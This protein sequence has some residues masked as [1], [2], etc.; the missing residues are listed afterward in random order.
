MATQTQRL[1]V[2][3]GIASLVGTLNYTIKG[4]LGTHVTR[5]T[6]GIT[7]GGLDGR[8]YYVDVVVNSAWLGAEVIWDDGTSEVSESLV[9]NLAAMLEVTGGGGGGGGA[10]TGAFAVTIA[11][12]DEEADPVMGANVRLRLGQSFYDPSDVDGEAN[13]SLDDGEYVLTITK[14]GYSFTP[15][16]VEVNG[17]DVSVEATLITSAV[18]DAPDAGMVTATLVTY[19]AIGTAQ[20]GKRVQFTL[21]SGP[22]ATGSSFSRENVI[23]TSGVGGVLNQTLLAS[24]TY[25]ARRESTVTNVWGEWT[26]VITPASGTFLLPEVLGR[27][28][29]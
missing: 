13:F 21:V 12:V 1:S 23:A 27:Q 6:T 7:A 9:A 16:I 15:M 14:A 22:G 29:V 10:G 20:V 28:N 18:P 5:R 8:R 4:P 24:S 26:K 17:A 25:R 11:V 2:D 19:D 3:W